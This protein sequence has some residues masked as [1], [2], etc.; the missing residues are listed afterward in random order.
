MKTC[1]TCKVE[2]P[3]EEF[4]K[5]K[6]NNDG[7]TYNCKVCRRADNKAWRDNNKEKVKEINARGHEKRK[8]Y[9]QSGVGI[10]SSRRAH[11]KRRFNMTLEE[12]NVMSEAQ[13]HKCYICGKPE[14]NNKNKVLCVDHNHET[15]AIRGLLCGLCNTGLGNFLDKKER[16]IKAIKYL[17]NYEK[18]NT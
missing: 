7:Y 2:K 5:D 16:L 8:A 11:L 13:E 4:G 12:Y 6:Y 14:M 10:E 9:Y 15:G 17:E 18:I 3:L 1:S